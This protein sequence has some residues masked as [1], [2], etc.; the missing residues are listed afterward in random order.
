[1]V[2]TEKYKLYLGRRERESEEKW[3]EE[4]RDRKEEE[5]GGEKVGY[6]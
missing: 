4:E 2:V 1:M 6:L 5:I 3:K